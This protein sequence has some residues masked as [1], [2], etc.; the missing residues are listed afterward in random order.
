M[1]ILRQPKFGDVTV[2]VRYFAGAQAAAGIAEEKLT[3]A[4]PTATPA[5]VRTL[6]AELVA[7]HGAIL[8]RVLAASSFIVDE[9]ASGPEQPL[10]DGAK[11][12]ILPPF[13]GG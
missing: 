2:S 6:V 4:S 5:T 12:D 13:A 11:I 8:A 9:V 3:L 7:R 10:P 1:T